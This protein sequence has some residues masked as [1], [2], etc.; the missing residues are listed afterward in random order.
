M[1]LDQ[2]HGYNMSLRLDRAQAAKAACSAGIPYLPSLV[3]MK[4]GVAGL[5]CWMIFFKQRQKL[6][7]KRAPSTVQAQEICQVR[8]A[9]ATNPMPPSMEV[10]VSTSSTRGNIS[11]TV[12]CAAQLDLT[13]FEL[14]SLHLEG[15]LL[16][17]WGCPQKAFLAGLCSDMFSFS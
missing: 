17:K 2:P 13:D 9:V 6:S 7:S 8:A 4:I 11:F 16:A 14:I 10:D 12:R 1:S 3:K 5:G 15:K